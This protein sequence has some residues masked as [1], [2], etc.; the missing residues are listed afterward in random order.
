MANSS[1]N[2]E[3]TRITMLLEAEVVCDGRTVIGR[4]RD[5]S[6]KGMLLACAETLPAGGACACTI[7]LDGRHG[8]ARIRAQAVVARSLDQAI[9]F[10][11]REL[12]DAESYQFLQN[13]VLYNAADPKRVEE[14]FK[15]H[16]GLKRPS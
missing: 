11:F 5:V 14:E 2:R 1:D 8:Q 13:L 6:L 12:A 16:L 3:F 9:A 15:N 4:T 10:E 7:F